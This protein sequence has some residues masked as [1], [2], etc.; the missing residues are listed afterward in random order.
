MP[1][2]IR[3]K[4]ASWIYQTSGTK[5]AV[6]SGAVGEYLVMARRSGADWFL[7]ALNN[8][9]TRVCATKLDFLGEE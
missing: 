1:E 3:L 4:H 8:D 5:P 2:A 9:Y 6:L 7:G